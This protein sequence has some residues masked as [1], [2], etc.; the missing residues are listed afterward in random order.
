MIAMAS[1][2]NHFG[3]EREA[4]FD[5]FYRK[6]EKDQLTIQKW[7]S[8]QA[9]TNAPSA[10]DNVKKIAAAG[11]AFSWENPGHIGSLIGGF[12]GNYQ[13]FHRAD[14]KGYEFIAD[15]VVKLDKINPST[16]SR[17]VGALCNWQSYTG[18]NRD[19]MIA[20]LERIAATPKLSANVADKVLKALPEG[21]AKKAATPAV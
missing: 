19:M 14:G 13:Q 16:A 12:A 17:I 1:I 8:M 18:A 11:K 4:V 3:P 6:F 15:C 7:F 20:Q 9:M 10:I 21:G 5:D 2:R